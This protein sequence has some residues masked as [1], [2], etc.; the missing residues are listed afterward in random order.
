M[1]VY[2]RATVKFRRDMKAGLSRAPRRPVL[3]LTVSGSVEGR[4][5]DSR[6][7]RKFVNPEVGPAGLGQALQ[8]GHSLAER[9]RQLRAG[10]AV[11]SLA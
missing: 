2:P 7:R 6:D 4:G 8:D 11:A 10:W 9:G 1:R 5:G 3:L